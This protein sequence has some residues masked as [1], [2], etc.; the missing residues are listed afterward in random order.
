LPLTLS[1]KPRERLVVNGA[2]LR[3]KSGRHPLTLE[4]LNKV[5]FMREREIVLP[6]HAVTPLL[7]VI[8][9][10]QLRYIDPEQR[11]LAQQRFLELARELHAAVAEPNIR[12]A[13]A[14][15]VAFAAQQRFGAALK[16]LRDALP[17]ERALLGLAAPDEPSTG[18]PASLVPVLAV[19]GRDVVADAPGLDP[20]VEEEPADLPLA[21]GRS[22]GPSP[23]HGEVRQAPASKGDVMSIKAYQKMQDQVTDPRRIEIMAFQQCTA[24]LVAASEARA[25][26]QDPCQPLASVKRV[27]EA[28]YKNDQLWIALLTDLASDSNR[29]PEAL[30]ARLISLGLWAQRYANEVRCKQASF[31]PLI[32]LNKQMIEGLSASL[33]ASL[34]ANLSA[35]AAPSAAP[36]APPAGPTQPISA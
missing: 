5:N 15:A 22:R 3:N 11:E 4:V 33:R 12:R 19:S 32:A 28:L 26:P 14:A 31:A 27:A 24:L 36:A 17:F 25:R 16:A 20:A 2:V 10:L 29:L 30:R 21:A 23:P 8:Y 35:G 9:W 18:G 6:E 1:L 7:R 34:S 13:V